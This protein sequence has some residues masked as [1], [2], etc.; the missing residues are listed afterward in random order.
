MKPFLI[1]LIGL[2]TAIALTLLL[3]GW[4]PSELRYDCRA[5]IGGWHPDV[6]LEVQQKCKEMQ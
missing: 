3:V 1:G 4:T 6:P 5:L 2:I